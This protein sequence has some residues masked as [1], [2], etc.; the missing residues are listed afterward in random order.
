MNFNTAIFYDVENLIGGYGFSQTTNVNFQLIRKRIKENEEKVL[1]ISISKAYGDWSNGRMQSLRNSL[2]DNGIEPVQVYGFASESGVKNVAD[3]QIVIDV[4]ETIT[5]KPH[6]ENF[7]LVTGDGGFASLVRKL[8]EFGKRVIICSYGAS[9]NRYLRAVC[10][11]FISLST[12][13]KTEELKDLKPKMLHIVSGLVNETTQRVNLSRIKETTRVELP[14]FS[15][16][17]L[18]YSR[19]IDFIGAILDGSMYMVINP[20]TGGECYVQKKSSTISPTVNKSLADQ[21][22]EVDISNIDSLKD[23]IIELTSFIAQKSDHIVLSLLMNNLQSFFPEFSVQ[24]YGFVSFKDFLRYCYA[25]SDFCLAT[26]E[27]AGVVICKRDNI[28]KRE[29]YEDIGMD[30][31]ASLVFK[32]LL[33]F[34]DRTTLKYIEQISKA[35]YDMVNGS[36]AYENTYNEFAH[37]IS[38]ELSIEEQ[39]VR[40][41]FGYLL[42]FGYIIVDENADVSLYEKPIS[43]FADC[44]VFS[45]IVTYVRETAQRYNIESGKA[46]DFIQSIGMETE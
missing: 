31:R 3:I 33:G 18:G 17:T 41:C 38:E 7:V 39:T 20:S 1:D 19:Y 13:G 15:E 10:D 4:M 26:D 36:P 2:L 32:R 44:D 28:G 34:D 21:S 8:H 30:E 5:N 12:S 35:L 23:F 11:N 45:T 29:R 42:K 14:D 37:A 40:R 16:S 46:N 43:L 24:K 9:A 27:Q 25:S 22:A 6:I